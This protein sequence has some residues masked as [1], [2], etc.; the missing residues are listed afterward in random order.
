MA[1]INAMANL[2][3]NN[4]PSFAVSSINASPQPVQF[5]V[6]F[7]PIAPLPQTFAGTNTTT[8]YST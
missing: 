7:N 6:S 2:F 5:I 8:S 4:L 1:T 3:Q